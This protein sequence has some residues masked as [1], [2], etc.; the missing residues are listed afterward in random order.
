VT[1]RFDPLVHAAPRL[2]LCALLVPVADAAFA[3]LRAALGVSDS[4][5]SKHLRVLE[6]AGYLGLHKTSSD[7]R[8][9]TRV[10]LTGTGRAAFAGHAAELQRLVGAG[11]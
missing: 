11:G 9:R 1:P 10:A 6:A 7:G 5:L 3:E 2:Q 8:V 4:V